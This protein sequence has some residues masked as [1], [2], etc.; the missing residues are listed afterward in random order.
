MVILSF[1]GWGQWLY[2]VVL[3]AAAQQ[4]ESALCTHVPLPSRVCFAAPTPSQSAELSSL[5][6]TAASHWLAVS[7]VVGYICHT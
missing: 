7:L 3:A 4:S 5:C 1:F 6:R 2:N